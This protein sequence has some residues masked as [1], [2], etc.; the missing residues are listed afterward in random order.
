M[1]DL[2]LQN[3]DPGLR[4]HFVCYKIPDSL[5]KMHELSRHL[6]NS[7]VASSQRLGALGR[8]LGWSSNDSNAIRN[9]GNF[10]GFLC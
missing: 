5:S 7:L 1:F 6:M 8:L 2:I 4:T 3:M 10:R 9:R